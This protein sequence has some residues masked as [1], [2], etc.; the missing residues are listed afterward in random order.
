M[1]SLLDAIIKQS[2]RTL[3]KHATGFEYRIKRNCLVS[4]K[5]CL[6]LNT[7][8]ATSYDWWQYFRII[9]GIAVF[10][11]HRYS[12]T[13]AKHQRDMEY[14]LNKLGIRIDVY[15]NTRQSLGGWSLTDVLEC[16]GKQLVEQQERL[17]TCVRKESRKRSD[18][19]WEIERIT[20]YVELISKRIGAA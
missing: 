16:L 10:N 6:D 4:T 5:N 11:E 7:L 17:A 13:T 8:V 19:E 2:T 14:L 15:V 20:G 3:V 9:D 1:N 12:V 18:T